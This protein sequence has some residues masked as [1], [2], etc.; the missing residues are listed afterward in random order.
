MKAKQESP[1][2]FD[3]VNITT[4]LNSDCIQPILVMASRHPTTIIERS[5]WLSIFVS[6]SVS[7]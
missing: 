6:G 7:A 3:T 1:F 4:I 2:F 5:V